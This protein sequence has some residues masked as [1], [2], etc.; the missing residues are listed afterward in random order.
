[1]K[2]TVVTQ[3]ARL[4]QT[5]AIRQGIARE[6]TGVAG[7]RTQQNKRDHEKKKRKEGENN[8]KELTILIVFSRT[9]MLLTVLCL[10]LLFVF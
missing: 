3:T 5:V 2:K 1:M 10:A 8:K 6:N 9:Y 4:T 7:T